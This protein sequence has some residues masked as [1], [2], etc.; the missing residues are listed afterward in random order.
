MNGL[1][2]FKETGEWSIDAVPNEGEAS[3]K[4]MMVHTINKHVQI[5]LLSTYV[6]K[7]ST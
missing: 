6:V 5:C 7:I 1:F 2:F 4:P 3:I